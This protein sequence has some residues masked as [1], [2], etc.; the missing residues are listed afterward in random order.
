MAQ[1]NYSIYDI[2]EFSNTKE[3]T[4]TFLQARHLIHSN[5]ICTRCGQILKLS[6]LSKNINV[7]YILRCP[8]KAC[9]YQQSLISDTFFHRL[10]FPLQKYI[11]VFY[12]WASQTPI[13]IAAEHLQISANTLVEHYNF[14]RDICSW[15]LIQEPIKLGGIDIVVQIDESVIVKAKYNRGHALHRAQRWI[16]GIYDTNSKT[17]YICF[18]NNRDVDTLQPIILSIVSPGSII[19][20]DCW[21][22]YNFIDHLPHPQP[23]RHG[24]VN[25]SQTFLDPITGV[26]TN[27][28]EALW[29]RCKKR[30]KQM[31]GTSDNMVPGYLDEYM[32]RER[33]GATSSESFDNILAHISQRYPI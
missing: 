26:H 23:Y 29:S 32:W 3:S 27:H 17:S 12:Y 9:R 4:I 33:Y 16:F 6:E 2:T 31:N 7:G 11:A 20:S 25:H 5:V 15:K 1:R 14:L 18:V 30:F 28:V 19:H 21:A 13:H 10:H 8:N 24:T 22:T